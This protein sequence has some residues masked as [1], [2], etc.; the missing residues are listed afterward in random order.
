MLFNGAVN[1]NFL[2]SVVAENKGM[3]HSY[4]GPDKE[5]LK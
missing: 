4:K 2:A 5:K 3:E 1:C